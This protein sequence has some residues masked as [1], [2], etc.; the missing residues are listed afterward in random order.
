MLKISALYLSYTYEDSSVL[1]RIPAIV[2][3]DININIFKPTTPEDVDTFVD[4]IKCD[5]LEKKFT[6]FNS[7]NYRK[8]I[9]RDEPINNK[10]W[11]KIFPDF[12]I[13]TAGKRN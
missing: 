7:F 12:V 6:A 3:E 8:D 5:S 9:Q 4:S 1:L 2:I 10:R 11:L 13:Q